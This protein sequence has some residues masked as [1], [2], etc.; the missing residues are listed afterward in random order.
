MKLI[1]NT[2]YYNVYSLENGKEV[3][4]I[5]FYEPTTGEVIV[6]TDWFSIGGSGNNDYPVVDFPFDIV[7]KIKLPTK[8]PTDHGFYIKP[9]D[10]HLVNRDKVDV[11]IPATSVNLVKL[12]NSVVQTDAI[13]GEWNYEYYGLHLNCSSKTDDKIDL[14]EVR[15]Q[16]FSGFTPTEESEYNK[17]LY[18]EL[19]ELGVDISLYQIPTLLEIYDLIKKVVK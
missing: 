14:R 9:S 2:T 18:L 19:K 13:N 6:S 15:I 10:S 1:K 16:K 8:Y 4:Q 7:R 11:Y 3:N 5:C 12:K 17:Q